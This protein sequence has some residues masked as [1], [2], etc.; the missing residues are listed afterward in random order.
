[1]GRSYMNIQIVLQIYSAKLIT[2]HRS[3]VMLYKQ[4]L[5][6]LDKI[7]ERLTHLTTSG[8][9]IM[10]YAFQQINLFSRSK[11]KQFVLKLTSRIS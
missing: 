5:F 9:N 2:Q 7:A 4:P 10:Y 6:P 3:F 1:M 11:R 8:C